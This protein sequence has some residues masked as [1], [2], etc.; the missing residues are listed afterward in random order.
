[1]E[2]VTAAELR[3][4]LNA[5]L[6][7]PR[8]WQDLADIVHAGASR[9]EPG[10]RELVRAWEAA[11]ASGREHAGIGRLAEGLAR[12]A[13]R[14][15]PMARELRHWL[16]VPGRPGEDRD[17][18]RLPGRA[19]SDRSRS[20]V[21]EA[22]PGTGAGAAAR[23]T[24]SDHAT[25]TGTV[26]QAHGIHGD[27]HV[28]TAPVA[29]ATPVPSSADASAVCQLLPVPVHF[30]NREQELA[31][32]HDLA[33]RAR[34][35]PG[36]AVISGPAGV[37][38]TAL[39]S[40]W[41]HDLAAE[42]PDGQLYA[43]L[44][45][46]T[47]ADEPAAPAEILGQFLRSLGVTQLPLDLSELA[48]LWR[49]RTYGRRVAVMLDNALS[50]A[51]VRP[52]LPGGA[53]SLVA[54]TSRLRLT[55]LSIDGAVFQPLGVLDSGD[56]VEL[57]SRRIGAGRV[58][59]EPEAAR[60]VVDLCAGLPL[61]VC[62]VAARMAV[63]P[64]Q[65]LAAMAGALGRD[66]VS[67][68]EALRVEGRHAVRAAL[69]ASYRHLP[70]ELALGYRRLGVVPVT[71][72]NGPIAAAACA[73]DPGQ[74]D[75]L[76]DALAE[77]NLL[78]DLGP[79]HTSGLDR[80][81]FHDLV[82][83]HAGDLAARTEDARDRRETVRRF[84]DLYLATATAAEALLSPSHRTLARC[85][86]FEPEQPPAFTDA[87][88]ALKWL[89]SERLHLMVAL[90]TAAEQ[91]WDATA[92]QLADA[93]WP[94]FLRLRPYD[95][96]ITAHEIGLAAARRDGDREGESRM[97]TS[98]GTGL[99]NA[100]RHDEAITWFEEARDAARR[101]GD[102]KGEAQAL[103]GLGQA[104]RLA[105]RLSQATHFFRRALV[106]RETIGHER[107][108]ALTRL[109]LGDVA[110][111]DGRP[112]QALP[113]LVR[114]R[115]Q[116][117]AVDDPYDAARALA[118]LARARARRDDSEREQAERELLQSL[119]EFE[120]S[121]SVH[122]Q[123]RVLEMLGDMAAEGGD[124]AGARYWYEQSLARYTPVSAADVGRLEGRLRE[125]AGHRRTEE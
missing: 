6:A 63:R 108:S 3:T 46:H 25:V 75:R 92:W 22:A 116:L 113:L 104:H 122:W 78:E 118:H 71:V 34:D 61:A 115:A 85:Y 38:K 109:C 29:P 105:G 39:A 107:G 91:G 7:R 66:G 5:A 59:R 10:A 94:L 33:R 65:P 12:Q 98:G 15:G 32:L 31:A 14:H 103:H 119:R 35:A 26:I 60:Q 43:D 123:G 50:A 96:W 42:F 49:S 110:L 54:V 19:E 114:A 112:E 82:R 102:G 41:L 45:G 117:L 11:G 100:G 2:T 53:G 13:A 28:H 121:G 79:D 101:D 95:L 80:Y 67:G 106:L 23:N 111:A 120:E 37:G 20:P 97:L 9:D 124:P 56:A 4:A 69:D 125:L 48:A 81:R 84:V 89:D 62:V 27:V 99:R 51:Q 70:P 18:A 47:T 88:G 44:R 76:L 36:V 72:F 58:R 8:L 93:M 64:R 83:A 24:V 87:A 30:I 74:A 86:A 55:G 17:G 40:R 77:T 68:L 1:M 73:V 57:L 16:A 52:L 21:A 90:R